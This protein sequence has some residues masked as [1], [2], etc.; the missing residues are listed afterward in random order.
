M[1]P[2]F[3]NSNPM[4]TTSTILTIESGDAA[5]R[6]SRNHSTDMSSEAIARRFDVVDELNQ[7]CRWLGTAKSVGKVDQKKMSRS[8]PVSIC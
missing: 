8:K 1:S 6:A 7:L 4:P 3:N 2:I 5:K